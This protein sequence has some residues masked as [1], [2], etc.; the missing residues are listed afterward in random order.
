MQNFGNETLVAADLVCNG[1]LYL[2]ECDHE[3]SGIK[4]TNICVFSELAKSPV[5]YLNNFLLLCIS[6]LDFF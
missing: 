5:D 4:S 1:L 3:R 2:F 6:T